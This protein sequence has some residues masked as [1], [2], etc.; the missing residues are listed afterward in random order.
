M[1]LARS[2]AVTSAN[3]PIAALIAVLLLA[4]GC[5]S[6][7]SLI[8]REQRHV[9]DRA[10]VEYPPHFELTVFAH[11]LTA[12]ECIAFD[13]D[14]PVHKGT[15][16]VAEAGAGGTSV[17]IYRFN[18]DGK[19]VD[20]YPR[21]GH[22]PGL[23]ELTNFTGL[24]KEPLEIYPPI[25]GMAVHGGKL[26]VSH[27]DAQGLG[28]VTAIGYDGSAITLAAGLPAQGEY[29]V[30]DIA[31]QP[32]DGR[33]FFGMGAATNSGV[34]GLDDWD[35]GFPRQ[36]PDACDVPWKPLQLLGYRFDTPNPLAGLF[37]PADR[38][39]TAP[40]QPFNSGN[41]LVITPLDDKP[42]S[43]IYSV[44][45]AGGDLRVEAHGIRD[46]R[47]L[48]FNDFGA[49]YFTNDG[50]EMRGSRP[51]KD[52]PD[53]LLRLVPNTWYGFPDYTTDLQ[54]VENPRFQPP[55]ELMA[56]SS[57]PEIRALIDREASHLGQPST[58]RQSLV[59]GIFPSLSHAAKFMFVPLS[60]LGPA[61]KPFAGNAI[62]A[63]SGDRAP[64]DNSGMALARSLGYKVVRVDPDAAEPNAFDFVHNTADKPAHML[65]RDSS[66]ALE[67]PIDVKLGPD[68]ALYILDFGRMHMLDG[69]EK[70]ATHTG[71]IYRLAPIP[72]PT[73]Q[74]AAAGQ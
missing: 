16:F 3:A 64:F 56:R 50:M 35:I 46:P 31:V 37:G 36:Y 44:S 22:V 33:I 34:V 47:G 60:G 45:P 25:G 19:R 18:P 24:T 15:L 66:D 53:A 67:R 6:G 14:D 40:F 21:P 69:R 48:A 2:R 10:N 13:Y 49:L 52:D 58:Y 11:G 7:P 68:G 30:T 43:A 32:S 61:Y 74:P 54:S 20:L 42:N 72:G 26:Y 59:K 38:A 65:G 27:R 41:R 57:Y 51:V 70:V 73:T 5:L 62:V 23:T 17:R 63:L 39:V 9:I 4:G 28:R 8:P 71:R 29:S 12:P 55:P 1:L